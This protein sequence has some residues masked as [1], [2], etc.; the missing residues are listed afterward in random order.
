[1]TKQEIE[2][3]AIIKLINWGEFS[4]RPDAIGI[5]KHCLF[6]G[7]NSHDISLKEFRDIYYSFISTINDET[8][9]R[10]ERGLP[11]FAPDISHG[12][13]DCHFM[14]LPAHLVGLGK[15]AVDKYLNGALIDFPV[16]ECLSY[17]FQDTYFSDEEE[18]AMLG[19]S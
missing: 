6:N 3:W 19:D 16:V 7:I 12:A 4:V 10:C 8:L 18:A 13:D 5:A 1:M 17:M 2:F 9:R 11:S 15:K 14:D